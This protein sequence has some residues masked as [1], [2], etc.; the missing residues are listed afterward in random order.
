M[1]QFIAVIILFFSLRCYSQTSV[2]GQPY[3]AASIDQYMWSYSK[4]KAA[5]N[6]KPLI[7][8][9][10]IDNWKGFGNYLKVSDDGKYFSYTINRADPE[11]RM[12]SV[13]L[14][15]DSLVVQ[16][17]RND[18]RRAFAG[19][20]KGFFTADGKQYIF[21]NGGS[22]CF[23]LLGSKQQK[24]VNDIASF[25]SSQNKWLAYQL[26]DKDDLILQNLLTGKVKQL[27]GAAD[28]NFDNSGHWL[29]C[30][31]DGTK[32]LRLYNPENG[33]EKEFSNVSEY[34]LT[35][36]GNTLLLKTMENAA[37]SLHYINL[38][39]PNSKLIWEAKGKAG[40]N[41]FSMDASG[42]RVVFSITDSAE[43]ARTNVLYYEAGMD[44]AVLRIS[45]SAPVIRVGF[46]I[47]NV[48]FTD[49]GQYIKLLLQSKPGEEGNRDENLAGVEVWNHK[50]LN[51]QSAQVKQLRRT[52]TYNAIASIEGKIVLLENNNKKIALIG[53][54][55]A[56][57]K[58]DYKEQIGDRFWEKTEDSSWLVSLKNGCSILLPTKSQRFWFSP[59]GNYL[60]YVDA[61][62]GFHYFS[63]DLHTKVLNDISSDVPEDQ[64]GYAYGASDDV[65][66]KMSNL[67]AWVGNDAEVLAYGKYDIWK[68]D[69]SGKKPALNITNGFGQAN[70]AIFNLF[71]TDHYSSEVPIIKPNES[72]VLRGFNAG[73]KQSGF[74]KKKLGETGNP[75]ELYMG[76]YFMNQ[77]MGCQDPNLSND[78]FAPVE[79]KSSNSWIVQRQSANDAPNYYETSDF[80]NFRRLTDFQP[81]KNY[82]WFTEELVSFKYLDGKTGQGILYK[83][84]NFDPNKKYPVLIPFYGSFSNNMYQF[85]VPYYVYQAMA[86]AISPAWFLNNGFL[87]FTPDIAVEPGKFGPKAFS[88]IEGAAEYLKTLSYVDGNKIGIAS[89]SWGAKLATYIFNHS[90]SIAATAITEGMWYG[91]ILNVVLSTEENG[92][93]N[94]ED[95]ENGYG[96]GNIWGNKNIWLDH[97]TVLNVDKAV[98]PLLLLCNKESSPEYQN[99]TLQ[100]FTALRRLDK[101]VWWLKYDKGNHVLSYNEEAKDYTIRYTQFFDHYLKNAP[102]PLWMT[103]GVPYK[104]KG[105]ESRYELDPQGTCN[106]PNGEPCP[107]CQAWNAQFKKTPEMFTKEIKDWMLDKD[108]A[109]SLRQAQDD[110]RKE[111]DKEGAVRAKEVMRMLNAPVKKA[112]Q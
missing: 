110:K 14:I 101:K 105:I 65:K 22:L 66:A 56:L 11:F 12:Q 102:A 32:K 7:N 21:K 30:W 109:E 74:Y 39:S 18:W 19:A 57:V 112:Q 25:K 87:V 41:S 72:L 68:L 37:S 104:L 8:F 43:A 93:S 83:P 52:R 59:G 36:N 111:L 78:G 80:K 24:L 82:Q 29:V 77:I 20:E 5:P 71:T 85:S 95:A 69:L 28:F 103:E 27:A 91:N 54:D 61:D 33:I 42:K 106:A 100:F 94:L 51:L 13:L 96:F 4:N 88:V 40:I 70:S 3:S 84:E 44:Q 67:A 64:F 17:T 46:T 60:V 97:T 79:A 34:T 47:G 99:Q 98:S 73:N 38:L 58:N 16:S 23:L 76:G 49:N 108:I 81:Q 55:F 1:K 15:V 45:N 31:N 63:Y 2:K 48:S 10:V 53:D 90:T 26:K 6:K 50:D 75:T 9:D 107:I 92:R 89:H 86:P 62:K 35:E